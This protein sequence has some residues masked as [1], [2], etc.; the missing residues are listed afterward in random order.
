ME[1]KILFWQ[2]RVKITQVPELFEPATIPETAV[3]FYQK[4][5][6]T[7]SFLY[8][9]FGM[10][11]PGTY[12]LELTA[13]D[14]VEVTFFTKAESECEAIKVGHAW[15]SNLRYKFMGLDGTVEAK[16]ILKGDPEMP[17][18]SQIKEL[19][20]PKGYIK[21]KIN[22]IERFISAFYYTKD[23]IIRTLILW[24]RE[25]RSEESME[26][27]NVFN[28]RVF[29]EY[30]PENLD[31][32]DKLKLE[33]ILQFLS[34]D[35]ENQVGDR[36]KIVDQPDVSHLEI[37]EG[38]VF[39][40]GN[41]SLRNFVQEDVNFDFPENLPL[42]RLPILHNENVRYID[43]QDE[44]KKEAIKVGRHI[45]SGV[46]TNHITYVPIRKLPQDVVI[47]GKPGCGKTYFLAR[48][49]QELSEKAKNFGILV[50]NVAKSSQEI[51]YRNFSVI[52]YTDTNFHIPYFIEG[53]SLE[54][55]LQ[56]TATYICTSLGLKNVFEKIIYR[57]GIAFINKK[58]EL[59]E[60]MNTLLKAVE[61]YVRNN[62]YGSDVQ[63]N[64]L[65]ALRNRIRVFSGDKIQDVLKLST[66]LPDWFKDWMDGKR[67]F[68]DVSMCNKFTK[69]LIVNAIFQLVRT[70]TKDIEAEELKHVIV[71][72]EAHAILEKPITRNSDDADFIMKEQMAKIFSELLKEYRSRG[73]GFVIADQSPARLFDDVASQPSIKVIF[74]EDYPNNT[75]F[76]EDPFERQ[77]LT[78][79]E[80]RVAI[81]INGATGEKFLIK[82]L[83]Y[84]L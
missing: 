26:Q 22:I 5:E 49:I 11:P 83:D 21:N 32:K 73:V 46:I 8:D 66:G 19:F 67:I 59:P 31:I 43:I 37:L 51:Y 33:G 79:L 9:P 28:L 61:S 20:L 55:A 6:D 72:D 25:P 60:Y 81:V 1:K 74:R 3:P 48:F 57:T 29:I 63:A 7:R 4:H 38:N 71:I 54:K 68:L 84:D 56:E 34:M 12:G 36:A 18:H 70:M 27:S 41:D 45:K 30:N 16:P 13:N 65:Q 76:S 47:F 15:L 52:K 78:Q 39:N 58:G 40:G 14:N 42:P 17:N 62:P 44:F 75:I 2:A 24:K 80:N 69:Q 10:N 50:M 35:I 77:I 53:E 23:Q 64:L 82:T